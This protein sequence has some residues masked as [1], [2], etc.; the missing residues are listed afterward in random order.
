LVLA[1]RELT[2]L[3]GF[4]ARVTELIRVLEE[5][6]QGKYERTMLEDSTIKGSPLVPNSG[7][8]IEQ[9]RIIKFEDVPIVTPNG[10]VL[11]ESLNFEVTSGMN[12]LVCG[13]SC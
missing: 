4:T 10:D 5:L 7:K 11:V 13:V 2:R 6:N 3:A 8:F 9:D 1:G 12:C